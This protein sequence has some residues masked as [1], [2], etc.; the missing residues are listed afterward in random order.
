VL[1]LRGR[2]FCLLQMQRSAGQI[3]AAVTM[4]PLVD[5]GGR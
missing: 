4:A 5:F 1:Y 2:I 3:L